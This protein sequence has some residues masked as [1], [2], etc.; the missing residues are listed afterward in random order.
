MG[1]ISYWFYDAFSGMK[2]NM[3]NVLISTGTMIAVM[4][5]V[6][7]A[8][9]VVQN[10][11]FIIKKKQ[12]SVSKIVAYLD[13]NVTSEQV[14]EIKRAVSKISGATD[15]VYT[16][17]EEALE[18]AKNS[19]LA[20]IFDDISEEDLAKMLPG[21]ITVTFDSVSAEERIVAELKTLDGVGK[22]KKDIVV[23][24]SAVD[25]IKKANTIRIIGYTLLV[26]VIELSVFL[27]M[28]STKLMLYAKRKEISIM[29]YVGATD[30]F[31]KVPF[32]IQAIFTALVAAVVT[33]VI[34]S[35]LYDFV[36]SKMTSYTLLSGSQIMF[37]LTLILLAVGVVIGI[38]G[39]SVSMNKYLDV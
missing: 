36:V 33:M 11:E 24:D 32:I 8:F 29:K 18:K 20:E 4:L 2:K 39:S 30:G 23:A 35:M 31:I 7:V 17:Q 27:I 9:I 14:N 34:V 12:D 25:A 38:T 26:L 19:D 22:D 37:K 16:S 3:K 28:N 15:V 10:A 6:A 5:I 1:T 13:Y 21:N